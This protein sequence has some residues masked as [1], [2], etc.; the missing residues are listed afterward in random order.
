MTNRMIVVKAARD[1]EAGVWYVESSDL[2]GLNLEADTLEGLV[3]KLPAAIQDLLADGGL[4][5]GR[6]GEDRDVP[7]ELIAHAST[8]VRIAAV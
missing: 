2:S 1:T 5:D 8:R 7:I 6:D 3:D 4:D